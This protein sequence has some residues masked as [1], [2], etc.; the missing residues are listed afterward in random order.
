MLGYALTFFIVALV[1]AVLGF[2]GIAGAAVNFA[3]LL[4]VVF[5]ILAVAAYVRGH[6]R[7]A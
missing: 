2:T 5:A 4:C 6:G 7:A 1:A 3:W